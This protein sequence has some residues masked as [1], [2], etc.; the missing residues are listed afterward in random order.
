MLVG[1]LL[2]KVIMDI[3]FILGKVGSG[4]MLFDLI[5]MFRLWN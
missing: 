1:G 5:E 2:N 4:L 3:F